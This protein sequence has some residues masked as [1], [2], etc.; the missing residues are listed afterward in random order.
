MKG[1]I[2]NLIKENKIVFLSFIITIGILIVAS[3]HD[4]RPSI[5]MNELSAQGY[6]VEQIEFEFFKDSVGVREWV[7]RST[8]PIFYNENYVEYWLLRRHIF[9]LLWPNLRTVYTIEPY[10]M[11]EQLTKH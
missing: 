4:G 3:L 11:K 1:K 10:L 9:G 5:I 7:F 6:N 8:E 2:Q